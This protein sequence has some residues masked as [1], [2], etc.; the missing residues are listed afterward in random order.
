MILH[1]ASFSAPIS[2]CW[3]LLPAHGQ[4]RQVKRRGLVNSLIQFPNRRCAWLRQRFSGRRCA[5]SFGKQFM[6][7][8]RRAWFL[9]GEHREGAA[10]LSVIDWQMREELAREPTKGFS[11]ALRGALTRGA[12]LTAPSGGGRGKR[13]TW[14]SCTTRDCQVREKHQKRCRVSFDPCLS[15][16][17]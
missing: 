8:T 3:Q 12:A 2:D 11:L 9:P 5:S 17:P 10:R 15:S 14:Y 16:M 7:S 13:R 1:I 6:G 4:A